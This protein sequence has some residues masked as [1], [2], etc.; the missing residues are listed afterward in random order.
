MPANHRRCR[1]ASD[2]RGLLLRRID[3]RLLLAS[4]GPLRVVGLGCTEVMNAFQMSTSAGVE[5]EG[6]PDVVVCVNPTAAELERAATLLNGK[7]YLYSEWPGHRG[8]QTGLIRKQLEAAGFEIEASFITDVS[9]SAR[10]PEWWIPVDSPNA[11]RYA[12]ANR[13]HVRG[14]A[15]QLRRALK[16]LALRLTSMWLSRPVCV[17]AR[18]RATENCSSHASHNSVDGPTRLL[19]IGRYIRSQWSDW[20]LGSEPVHMSLML[21][22]WGRSVRNKVIILVFDKSQAEPRLIIKTART[23]DV[24]PALDREANVLQ[25]LDTL[26]PG[27]QG[28]PK[29]LFREQA[30]RSLLIGQ[31]VIGGRRASKV[32]SQRSLPKILERA[33]AWQIRLAHASGSRGETSIGDNRVADI[34]DCFETTFGS[35]TD[36]GLILEC[37][38]RLADLPALPVVCEQRDFGP[39]NVFIDSKN[40]LSV[41]DWEGGEINGL[42]ALDLIHFVTYAAIYLDRAH[43]TGEYAAAYR[44]IFSLETRNGRLVTAA[45]ERYA[46]SVGVPTGALAALRLVTWMLHACRRQ[47]IDGNSSIALKDNLFG[48]LWKTELNHM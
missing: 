13:G 2:D 33:T 26:T 25:H 14:R 8:W 17:L 40:N 43:E 29:V 31:S 39:W 20:E 27:I 28:I 11:L 34:R 24:T 6:E 16:T 37:R 47:E 32:I 44:G 15:R 41:V 22:T 21:Q 38:R 5:T 10:L 45:L 12:L 46:V 18:R 35:T 42:P 4:P 9:P 30:G 19:D 3:W 48:I 7:G 23:E 1:I 36:P